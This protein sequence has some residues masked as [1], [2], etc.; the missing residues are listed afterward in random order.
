MGRFLQIYP[1]AISAARIAI[2]ATADAVL[3][4]FA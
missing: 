1:R 4:G 2:A 3:L